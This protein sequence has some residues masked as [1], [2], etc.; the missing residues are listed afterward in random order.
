[1]SH[2]LEH[3]AA[4][5][6]ID[7]REVDIQPIQKF[8]S[9][10]GGFIFPVL[11]HATDKIDILGLLVALSIEVLGF[12]FGVNIGMLFKHVVHPGK[13]GMARS[14]IDHVFTSLLDDLGNVDT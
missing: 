9:C 3:T 12:I 7:E 6:L 4:A 2:I 11:A 13:D 1:M 14:N 10:L 5:D 8:Q